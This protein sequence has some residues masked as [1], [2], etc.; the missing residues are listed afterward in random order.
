MPFGGEPGYVAGYLYAYTTSFLTAANGYQF[1]ST[2]PQAE[3]NAAIT[4]ANQRIAPPL[5][6][7]VANERTLRE[8]A[9]A[10]MDTNR[11]YIAR[12][13]PTT[14]QNTAQ[15]KALSQQMNGVIRL[16]LGQFD[17]TN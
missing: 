14:A 10:A 17:G 6:P 1:Q 3:L 13:A 7:T 9:V 8:Q 15:I 2:A 16:L 11:V 4:S 12:S 5:P